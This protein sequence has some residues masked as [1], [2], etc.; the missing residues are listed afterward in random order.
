MA[1][2]TVPGSNSIWQYDNAATASNTYSDSVVEP[3]KLSSSINF[4]SSLRAPVILLITLKLSSTKFLILIV[5][6]S[7][8]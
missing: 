1:Y 7:F 8:T 3:F 5:I 2:V 4:S 6:I